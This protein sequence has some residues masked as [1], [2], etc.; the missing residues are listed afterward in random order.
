MF[1]CLM[2]FN[3]TLTW[4]GAI[5]R[6]SCQR[7]GSNRICDRRISVG[8]LSNS[9]LTTDPDG[10]YRH[11]RLRHSTIS[12]QPVRTILRHLSYCDCLF[13]LYWREHHLVIRKLRTRRQ[14]CRV[15]GNSANPHQYRWRGVWSNLPKQR[16][17]QVCFGPCVE[18]G[19]FGF[20][21]VRM[22]DYQ[23]DIQKERRE[24]GC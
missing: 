11:H 10:A 3:T 1:K 19:L 18:F 23:G 22:V 17:A 15:F 14:T 7:M 13:P 8:S 12:C 5:S 9:V 20:C 21:V 24:K 16:S 2:S 4:L 6:H